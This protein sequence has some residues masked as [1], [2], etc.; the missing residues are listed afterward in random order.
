MTNEEFAAMLDAQGGVCAI[1]GSDDPKS[2]GRGEVGSFHV[3]HDHKTGVVRGLLCSLCNRMLGQSQDSPAV[4]RA[5][6]AYLE[7][8]G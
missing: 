5:G 4:L 3:D 2:P 7:R 6:A 8:H 1:C